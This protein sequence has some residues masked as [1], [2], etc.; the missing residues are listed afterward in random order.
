MAPG[1][2]IIKLL[3][4]SRIP[5][6]T[7]GHLPTQFPKSSLPQKPASP[8]FSPSLGP[9]SRDVS[10]IQVPFLTPTHQ[11]SIHCGLCFQCALRVGPFLSTPATGTLAG[12]TASSLLSALPVPDPHLPIAARGHNLMHQSYYATTQFRDSRAPLTCRIKSKV[13]TTTFKAPCGLAAGPLSLQAP[14]HESFGLPTVPHITSPVLH[15]GP[16]SPGAL[17]SS[18]LHFTWITAPVSPL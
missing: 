12:A 2:V 6:A 18:S 7:L 13:S 8:P 16:C 1:S 11:L 10:L 14:L 5:Q 4:L 15:Q 9:Q 3:G 17:N